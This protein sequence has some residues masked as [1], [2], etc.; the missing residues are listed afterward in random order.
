MSLNKNTFFILLVF[1]QVFLPSVSHAGDWKF[2]ARETYDQ[3][4]IFDGPSESKY[5]GLSN[6]FNFWKEEPFDLSYGLVIGP[7]IGGAKAEDST[8]LYVDRVKLYFLGAEAK[9]FYYENFGLFSRAGIYYDYLDLSRSRWR[10]GLGLYIAV[11]YEFNISGVG[12]SLESG[13]RRSDLS[14][15]VV[16]QAL[17]FAL[18]VHFYE[19]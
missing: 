19:F 7:L 18:G 4:R 15:G 12:V 11:G 16:L 8:G 5:S 14:Q 17:S 2:R 9:Y 3:F 6:A 10:D 1:L 13:L